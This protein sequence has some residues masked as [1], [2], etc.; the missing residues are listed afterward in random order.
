LFG[1]DEDQRVQ[2]A[3]K[4]AVYWINHNRQI[5]KNTKL[6]FE[7]RILQTKDLF[8]STKEGIVLSTNTKLILYVI[9]RRKNL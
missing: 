1:E 9:F 5:S 3:F 4:Y 6:E 2:N 7:P 8:K